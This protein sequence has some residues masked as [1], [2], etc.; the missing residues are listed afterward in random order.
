MLV[1]SLYGGPVGD[2][3]VLRTDDNALAN[4]GLGNFEA[5]VLRDDLGELRSSYRVWPDPLVA[6]D[7][8]TQE[9]ALVRVAPEAPDAPESWDFAAPSP[10]L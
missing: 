1:G 3:L 10:G 2:A 7:P 5:V 8:A 4:A 9:A 6:P